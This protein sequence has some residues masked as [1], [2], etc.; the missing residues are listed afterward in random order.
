MRL[1][2]PSLA[3]R[4][5]DAIGIALIVIGV[6]LLCVTLIFARGSSTGEPDK[7]EAQ[8][9]ERD[10]EGPDSSD[11]PRRGRPVRSAL[12][13]APHLREQT[14]RSPHMRSERH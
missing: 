9:S 7:D 8:Q 4:E 10:E 1:E 11:A 14:E 3:G 5:M 6:V 2:I 13:A 12:A